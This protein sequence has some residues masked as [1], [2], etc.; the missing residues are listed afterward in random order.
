MS[1]NEVQQALIELALMKKHRDVA[2]ERY[3]LAEKRAIDALK[4]AGQKTVSAV[5]PDG[6]TVKG[7]LVQPQRVIID[8]ERLKKALPAPKWKK[9][10]KE[11][12]DKDKLEAAVALGEIDTNIVAGVSSV[13]DSKASVR[14][15]GDAT[16]VALEEQVAE[17]KAVTI[18][19]STGRVKPAA[20]GRVKPKG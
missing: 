19:D 17:N 20:K 6:E 18:R 5:F 1:L 14:L 15:S 2:A 10:V 8:E 11:V 12:L 4:A 3:A 13:V 16:L 7:T 9:V